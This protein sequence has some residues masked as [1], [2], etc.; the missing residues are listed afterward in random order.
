MHGHVQGRQPILDDA[1][2]VPGLQV[3]ERREVAVAEGQP[4]VVVADVQRRPQ[5][6]R[7]PVDETEVA[8]VPATPDPRRLERHAHRE[9]LG[10]SMSYSTASPVGRRAA[11]RKRSSAVRNS[12]SRKSSSGRP[13]TANSSVPGASRSSPPMESG[14]TDCTR[15]TAL[16][17][18]SRT[19]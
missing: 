17:Y 13:L 4:I 1:L 12:Q 10:R 16:P 14:A 2:H 8:V 6:V 3:R 5:A 9:T 7:V 18:P 11:K 19:L 15:I